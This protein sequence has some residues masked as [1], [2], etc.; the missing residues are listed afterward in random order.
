[1]SQSLSEAE[2]RKIHGKEDIR[3]LPC[4]RLMGWAARLLGR[5]YDRRNARPSLRFAASMTAANMARVQPNVEVFTS[6][7]TKDCG[8]LAKPKQEL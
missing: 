5:M 7:T 4:S 6:V 8:H 3:L 2:A 1:M